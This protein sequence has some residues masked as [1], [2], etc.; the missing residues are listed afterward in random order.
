M[1]FLAF[2]LGATSGR[3][4]I[5]TLE[6]GTL[7]LDE[8]HRFPNHIIKVNGHFH[9]NIFSLYEEILEGLR[10]AAAA[11][12]E[13]SSIGIDTWGVDVAFTGSDGAILGLPYSYRDPHTEGVPEEFFEKCISRDELYG[14]TGIQ[15]MNFNTLFQL[16]AMNRDGSSQLKAAEKILFIPDALSYLLTGKM[17]TEYTIASTSH[18]LDPR[19]KKLDTQLLASAGVDAGKF[20]PIVFPGHRTGTLRPEIARE[21]G[22]PELPVVAVAGHDTASAVAAVPALTEHF[23]Y[24]SSGTWSLMGIETK[25]PVLTPEAA[26]ANITN[27][28]GVEGTT[29]FLKN[30]TGMWIIE[31][32]LSEWKKA[33]KSYSYAD[34]APLAESGRR[35]CTFINPDDPSFANPASMQAAIDSYCAATGQQKP[36]SHGSYVRTVFESLALRY[37]QVLELIEKTAGFPVEVLHIIGGG[38]KNALLN[39]FT[40]DATGCTVAAGPSEATAIGNV[41]LQAYSAG[42]V[43]SLAAMRK[44]ISDCVEVERFQPRDTEQWD[45]AYEKYLER[46]DK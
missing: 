34:L 27:E 26:K 25:E 31:N 20:S 21:C 33:G 5:G 37:R 42:V 44:V 12:V 6:Q 16:Y 32:L 24:L 11:G 30:I 13:I 19:S 15:V 3:A 14:R 35:F 45:A 46:T 9:W 8:I 22:L 39:Q 10:K 23:A 1:N 4:I 17:V 18:F 28:G 38:S 29:R 7:R 40:A 36:D 43:D 2:D 41:M